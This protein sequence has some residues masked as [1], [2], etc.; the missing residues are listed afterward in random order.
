MDMIPV[1]SLFKG[2]RDICIKIGHDLYV[3][4]QFIISWYIMKKVL[5]LTDFTQHSLGAAKIGVNLCGKLKTNAILFNNHFYQPVAAPYDGGGWSVE[6]VVWLEEDRKKEAVRLEHKLLSATASW[7]PSMRKPHIG[8]SLREGDL[9]A[10]LEAILQEEDIKLVVMGARTGSGFDHLLTGSETN[11]VINHTSR[12]VLVIPDAT[13]ADLKKIVLATDLRNDDLNA[14]RYLADLAKLLDVEVEIVHVVV[15][16]EHET[17]Q[18]EAKKHMR[19][20]I[21]KFRSPHITFSEIRGK[22]TLAR[23]IRHCEE[24]QG[25]ILAIIHR[26]HGFFA[27]LL[28]RDVTEQALKQQTMPVLIIPAET[29]AGR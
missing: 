16:G 8:Y 11:A 15:Y 12:P 18:T 24:D 23:L 13:G 26:Q 9:G 20:A 1:I 28:G 2:H 27:R 10:N 17:D 21:A 19:A 29:K 5:I 22:D 3:D 6:D 14:I 4:L 25:D 7:P